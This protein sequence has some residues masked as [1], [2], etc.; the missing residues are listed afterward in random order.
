MNSEGSVLETWSS[1]DDEFMWGCEGLRPQKLT[2]VEPSK[3]ES[4][5][6]NVA[7]N[8]MLFAYKRTQ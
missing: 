4:V 1:K 5:L 7:E 8:Q 2:K 3:L 6:K